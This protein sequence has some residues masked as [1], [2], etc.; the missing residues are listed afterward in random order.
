METGHK[1]YLQFFQFHDF[2]KDEHGEIQM[3]GVPVAASKEQVGAAVDDLA[4]ECAAI[5]ERLTPAHGS[6]VLNQQRQMEYVRGFRNLVRPKE[7]EG[8]QQQYLIGILLGLSEKCLVWEGLMKEFEQTWESLESVMFQGGLQ[9]IVRNQSEEL[10][11]WFFQKYQSKFGE[12]ISPVTNN[13]DTIKVTKPNAPRKTMTSHRFWTT[14]DAA[15][16]LVNMCISIMTK[17]G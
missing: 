12:H 2:V 15:F 1:L 3:S 10:K 4:R 5:M 17:L 16:Q 8:A 14:V 11:N 7:Y 6:L 13:I 9:N